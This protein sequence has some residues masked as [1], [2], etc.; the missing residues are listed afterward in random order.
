MSDGCLAH[1]HLIEAVSNF[2]APCWHPLTLCPAAGT[3][4]SKARYDS[5]GTL[6]QPQSNI[7]PS[8]MSREPG[9][10]VQPALF[11]GSLVD[12]GG[13]PQALVIYHYYES[14]TTCEED[15][16]IQVIRT[17]LLTFLRYVNFIHRVPFEQKLCHARTIQ[18]RFL[19]MPD[20]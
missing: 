14:L 6:V 15:E 20:M 16:E 5:S 19:T 1:T 18:R 9:R 13:L 4:L 3:D 17:N 2:L 12:T 11:G 8:A 10:A 7:A